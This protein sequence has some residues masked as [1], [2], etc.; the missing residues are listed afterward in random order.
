MTEIVPSHKDQH[1]IHPLCCPI[2]PDTNTTPSRD[3]V[4]TSDIH[5]T[6]GINTSRGTTKT[7][8]T[9]TTRT[10]SAQTPRIDN[11]TAVP[12]NPGILPASIP[13]LIRR[14]VVNTTTCEEEGSLT[15]HVW[16]ADNCTTPP[17]PVT[18][19]GLQAF[20]KE[21]GDYNTEQGCYQVAFVLV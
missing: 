1:S 7:T 19:T 16:G 4:T 20:Q 3:L 6:N 18:S 15:L 17:L 12:G 5:I 13:T 14:V 11:I 21:L 10:T 8:T 2:S 9:R